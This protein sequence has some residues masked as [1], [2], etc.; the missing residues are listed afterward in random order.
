[1]SGT[2]TPYVSQHDGTENINN[3]TLV[4]GSITR[5]FQI[6]G[7]YATIFVYGTWDGATV[8]LQISPDKIKWFDY[9]TA[10]DDNHGID[11]IGNYWARWALTD[12]S[13]NSSVKAFIST[14][15]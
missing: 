4:K 11:Y 6:V 2:G 9:F 10:S 14:N 1:M 8:K 12:G 7:R 3:V 5:P 15:P 13:D